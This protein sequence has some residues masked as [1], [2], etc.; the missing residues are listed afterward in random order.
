MVKEDVIGLSHD[1]FACVGHDTSVLSICLSLELEHPHGMLY[2]GGDDGQVLQWKAGDGEL[3]RRLR[4]VEADTAAVLELHCVPGGVLAGHS[5]GSI[6]E[7]SHDGTLKRIWRLAG[8]VALS[9]MAVALRADEAG[10]QVV[11]FTGG[12]N[13][14]I[15]RYAC[16][17]EPEVRYEGGGGVPQCMAVAGDAL[18]VGSSDGHARQ[19]QI[20]TG[21]LMRVFHGHVAGLT[22]LAVIGDPDGDGLLFT[23]VAQP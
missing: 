7:W 1:S 18:F 8:G 5:D 23:G 19:W 9:T 2:T 20:Q 13:G 11:V 22:C 16:P 4:A 3:L 10:E 15:A 17:G 21:A 6:R 14:S 12:Q